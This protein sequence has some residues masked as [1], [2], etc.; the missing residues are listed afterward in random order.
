VRVLASMAAVL[1]ANSYSRSCRPRR[2]IIRCPACC[3]KKRGLE[4][5]RMHEVPSASVNLQRIDPR[6]PRGIVHQPSM[7]PKCVPPARREFGFQERALQMAREERSVVAARPRL[8]ELG[9]GAVVMNRQRAR[10]FPRQSQGRCRGR[11]AWPAP[12]TNDDSTFERFIAF[13]SYACQAYT[14]LKACENSSSVSAL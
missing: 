5:H 7:Q 1:P 9:F 8:P 12:V 14:W 13:Q 4:I 11:C 2:R 10:P 6:K 3:S